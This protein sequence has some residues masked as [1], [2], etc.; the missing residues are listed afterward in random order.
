VPGFELSD[1][2]ATARCTIRD[3]LAIVRMSCPTIFYRF[4]RS[5]RKSLL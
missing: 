2:D 5:V 4:A 3:L 1:L